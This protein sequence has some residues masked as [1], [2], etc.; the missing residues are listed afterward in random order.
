MII[1]FLSDNSV[2]IENYYTE[3]EY[4]DDIVLK[5]NEQFYEVYFYTKDAL[6]YE[7]TKDGFFAFPGMIILDIITTEKIITAVREL[8]K[9]GFF[10]RLK[11]LDNLNQLHRF[12]HDWY[13]NEI[14]PFNMDNIKTKMIEE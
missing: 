4:R 13:V 9:R 6:E 14:P 12:V 8:Q 5:I 7:M 3:K 1:Y 10:K 11:G 2:E